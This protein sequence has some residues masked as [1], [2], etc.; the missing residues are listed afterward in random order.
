[1]KFLP[2]MYMFVCLQDALRAKRNQEQFEREWRRKQKEEAEKKYV[3][4]AGCMYMHIQ[5]FI[6]NFLPR[7]GNWGWVMLFITLH[8]DFARVAIEGQES[9]DVDLN[10]ILEIFKLKNRRL[11]L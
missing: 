6:Q 5:G 11:L 8:V 9:K 7:G 2:F 10:E 4:M 3:E 1:M